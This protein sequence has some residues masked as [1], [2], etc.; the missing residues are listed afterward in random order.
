MHKLIA[1]IA[2]LAF[3]AGCAQTGEA[4]AASAS[5]SPWKPQSEVSI[6]HP[7]WSRDAV[8]YQINTRQFTKEGTFRAAQQELPRL[9]ELGVDILWLM[10]IHPIGVEN[11]KGTLGSPYSVQDY[12]AVNP[13]FGTKEDFRAFLDA[14]HEQASRSYSTSSPIIP[15]GITIS[16]NS[17]LN[18]TRK[19]G[20]V[21]SAPRHGGTGLTS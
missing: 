17:I 13:E 18:G 21:R 14:A 11:R 10:P 7:E 16:R 12:Y 6:E 20:R 5:S 19:I 3:L 4:P 9:K 15:H 1:T 2:A 8:L